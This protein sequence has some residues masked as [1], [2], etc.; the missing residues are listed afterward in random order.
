MD[1]EANKIGQLQLFRSEIGRDA[2]YAYYLA[3][4]LGQLQASIPFEDLARCIEYMVH[5]RKVEQ[6]VCGDNTVPNT[7][8]NKQPNQKLKG[9]C[10]PWF[11]LRGGMALCVLKSYYNDISDEKLIDLINGSRH[12]QWFCFM[13]LGLGEKIL[14]EDVVGRWRRYI[15]MHLN[16]DMN[17]QVLLKT[18]KSYIAHPHLRQM[19][20]TVYEVKIAYPTDV[21]LLWESCEWLYRQIGALDEAMGLPKGGK[22]G[23]SYRKYR[24]QK[25]KQI[26]FSKRK[27]KTYK[28]ERKRRKALLFWVA[29]GIDLL[30]ERVAQL[31]QQSKQNGQNGESE[32]AFA[33]NIAFSSRLKTIKAVYLQ[34]RFHYDNPKESVKQRIVSLHQPHIRTIVRGKENKKFEFGPKVHMLRVGCINLIESFSFEAFNEGTRFEKGCTKYQN[35]TG[36]CK[37]VGADNIYATNANHTFATKNH[38]CTSFKQKGRAPKNDEHKPL[39]RQTLGKIRA[40]QMEGSFGNEKNHYALNKVRAKNPYTQLAWIWTALL[41][42]NAVA[43]LKIKQ[44]KSK[45]NQPQTP[46]SK[47]KIRG[48]PNLMELVF[49]QNNEAA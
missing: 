49:G 7:G 23:S 12:L 36:A 43:I 2:E 10:R 5:K 35:I 15:G 17:N 1:E 31:A 28:Q 18:W 14:D 21:K 42:A 9:G 46:L 32:A 11:D 19:D 3:S 24:E 33:L 20:A 41:T 47:I 29:K 40:T 25:D 30:G 45:P 34:Q 26:A 39:M 13:Q 37:Q 8:V 4:E 6:N 48:K 38:I 22:T 44:Q 16:I 27:K